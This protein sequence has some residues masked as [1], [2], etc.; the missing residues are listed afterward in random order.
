MRFLVVTLNRTPIPL[1]MAPALLEGMR[2]WME[3]NS[4]TIE[5]I[6]SF[7]GVGGGGGIL[8]VESLEQLDAV[9]G[10]FPYG[11]FS[12]IQIYGLADLKQSLDGF[13]EMFKQ[14]AG[15]AGD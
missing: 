8:N 12:D 1:E 15:G 11:P 13:E 14:M 6:W 2:A 3:G 7:A 10:Q 9:M 4:D 5:Q